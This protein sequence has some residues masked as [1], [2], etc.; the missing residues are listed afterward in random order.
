[1]WKTTTLVKGAK[2]LEELEKMVIP[3]ANPQKKAWWAIFG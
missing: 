3:L 1:V 2:R